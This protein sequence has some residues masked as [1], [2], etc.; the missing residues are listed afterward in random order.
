MELHRKAYNKL[1]QWKREADGESAMLIEGA[2][3]VGKSYLARLFAKNEY[4][5][6]IYLDFANIEKDIIE[7]FENDI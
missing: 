6:Y 5:S 4:Q 1:L 2:R 3:R 7:L